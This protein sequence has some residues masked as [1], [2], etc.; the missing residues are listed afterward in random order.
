MKNSRYILLQAIATWRASLTTAEHDRLVKKANKIMAANL[1][2]E[3]K[4]SR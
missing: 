4:K 2:K 3:V 1:P